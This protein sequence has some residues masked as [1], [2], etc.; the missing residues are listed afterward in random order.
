MDFFRVWLVGYYNPSGFAR[1]LQGRPAPHW[2]LY[3]Q[4]L[5]A[6]LDA[7]LLYLPLA[8]MGRQPSMPSFLTFLPTER[9]F[10]ASVVLAPVFVLAQWLLLSAI[11]HVILRLSRQPSDIDQ[12]LNI[13]GM[14]AFIVGSFLVAWD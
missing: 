8:L 2:G 1:G 10:A 13:T 5:R 3:A 4:G 14:V 11:L 12:I 9:Y 7:L 6:L